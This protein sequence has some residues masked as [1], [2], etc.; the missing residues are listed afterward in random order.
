MGFRFPHES[1]DEITF[2]TTLSS[3]KTNVASIYISLPLCSNNESRK[4]ILRNDTNK[5]ITLGQIS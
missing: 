3:Y 5:P 4:L 2:I 1:K